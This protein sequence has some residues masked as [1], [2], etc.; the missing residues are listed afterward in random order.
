ME[1]DSYYCTTQ[2]LSIY[3]EIH[4]Y[5]IFYIMRIQEVNCH[6]NVLY[7]FHMIWGEVWPECVFKRLKG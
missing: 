2:K 1:S 5:F 7:I 6:E 3:I 4:F